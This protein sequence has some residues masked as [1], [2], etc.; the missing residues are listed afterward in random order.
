VGELRSGRLAGPIPHRTRPGRPRLPLR[1][2]GHG[3]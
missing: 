1:Q 2:G 3:A